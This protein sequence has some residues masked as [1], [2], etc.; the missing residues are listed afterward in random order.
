MNDQEIHTVTGAFG[1]SGKYIAKRLLKAGKTVRTL[2]NSTDHSGEL[3]D[4]IETYP[5]IFDDTD[6]LIESLQ[7]V[8]VLYNTYWIRFNYKTFSHSIAVDNT[9]KL[10]K[11]AKKAGVKRIVHTSITNPSEDSPLSYFSGKAILEK[12][13]KE[14]GISYSILR[15]AVL[16]GDEDILIN[17]IAWM[18]RKF[19]FFGVFGKGEYKLQPI[20]VDD[21]A[22]LALEQ[23]K[24]LENNVIDAIGP[25]TFT[26]KELVVKIG[27]IIGKKRPMISIS[28]NIGYFCGWL[29]GKFVNDVTITK[30]EIKGLSSNLLFTESKPVGI[31]KLTEWLNAN[32]S[33]VGIKYTSELKRR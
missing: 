5:L 32:S 6:K 18:L 21:F 20:F 25:E 30:A 27:E 15:P 23:G 8:S 2:T 3:K 11:A 28:D 12:E 7:G 29:I 13:L 26:Y 33:T 19:P 1:F 17:N 31:T 9:L 14:S 22:Q 16:F 4:K 10:F 24:S